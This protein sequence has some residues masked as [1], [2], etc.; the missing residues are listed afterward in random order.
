M[1][2]RIPYPILPVWQSSCELL[3]SRRSRER[4]VGQAAGPVSNHLPKR[5]ERAVGLHA[6]PVSIRTI[7][8]SDIRKPPGRPP[9]LR[10]TIRRSETRASCGAHR[11]VH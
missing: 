2:E 3:G 4:A 11:A 9:G 6:G 10:R 5:R 7:R 1:C 8:Q